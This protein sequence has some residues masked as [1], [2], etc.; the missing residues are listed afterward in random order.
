MYEKC[1]IN[2]KVALAIML[3]V[4]GHLR[5]VALIETS[6]NQDKPSLWDILR[7]PYPTAQLLK[8]MIDVVDSV[9]DF[10]QF[11]LVCG[12]NVCKYVNHKL[13]NEFINQ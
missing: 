5:E 13:W 3:S 10:A 12:C 9:F 6:S 11:R 1:Y 4:V 7:M 8:G 2:V